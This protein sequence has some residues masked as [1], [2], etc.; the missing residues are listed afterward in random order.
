MLL[1]VHLAAGEPMCE[2]WCVEKCEILNGNVN[3][4]CGDCLHRPGTDHYKC[5][6]AHVDDTPKPEGIVGESKVSADP[7]SGPRC[8][9]LSP[10]DA[11]DRDSLCIRIA[12]SAPGFGDLVFVNMS[13]SETRATSVGQTIPQGGESTF[14]IRDGV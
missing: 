8:G 4:E 2:P 10:Q 11:V 6:P 3:Q 5:R 7:S 9:C 1:L 12:H 14:S 13:A